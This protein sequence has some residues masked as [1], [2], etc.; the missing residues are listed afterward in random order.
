MI[1]QFDNAYI[2]ETKHTSYVMRV[3]PS[4][5]IEHLYYGPKITM[6]KVE[7]DPT[8]GESV[9]DPFLPLYEKH[10]FAPGDTAIYGPG[11]ENFTL[12]DMNL[13]YSTLG[14][15]DQREPLLI[16]RHGDGSVTS[17][18][19]VENVMMYSH[20]EH[21]GSLTTLPSSYGSCE[22][23]VFF[24]T[25]HVHSMEL[26]IHYLVYEAYDVICRFQK[27]INRNDE[28]VVLERFL[29]NQLDF[30]DSE[31]VFTTFNGAWTR[32]MNRND[33]LL[34]QGKIVNDSM[35][36]ASS[37]EANPFVMISRLGTTED[38]GQC[39]GCNLIYSGN[40]MEIA[41][42]S[43]YGKLHVLQGLHEKY[44]SWHL[45]SGESFE[46]PEAV[47]T[48]S[49]DGMNGMSQNMHEFVRNCIVRGRY[50]DRVRPVLLNSWEASYFH[51]TEESL[52]RLAKAGAKVGVELFVMDDGWFGKR[53]DDKH[54]LGDWE[55]N[56]EKLPG[57]LMAL[58]EKI[59]GLGMEFGIWV[60]PEMVNTDSDLY[61]RH[62]EWVLQIP[63][64]PHSEG[65]NQ[66]I[67]DLSQVEVQEYLIHAMSKVFSSAKI[68][69]VKWDMN[70]NWTDVY[71]NVY[72]T[73][74]QG[75]V[76]HRYMMGLYRVMKELTESFP[77]IL[78]EGC[79]S[80]GDRFDL[81]ILCYF[82]QIWAS[83]NTDALSRISIQTGLSYGY[84]L[85]T[86]GAH[87]S[88]VPNHQTLRITPLS[89]R[90]AVAAFG[91]LGYEMNLCDATKEELDAI[92]NQIATYKA[93]RSTIQWG[94][95]YRGRTLDGGLTGLAGSVQYGLMG[96]MTKGRFAEWTVVSKNR[97]RAMGMV[98]Q[99]QLI[100][101]SAHYT[102]HAK[103]LDGKKMYYFYH[104]PEVVNVQ[105]FG[106]LLNTM[107]PV[108]VKQDS[109][110]HKTIA[111]VVKLPGEKEEFMA[112]GDTLMYGGVKLSES[113]QGT[114]FN[115]KTRVMPDYGARLYYM[116]TEE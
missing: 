32:E 111:K 22:E 107:T 27:I 92:R 46:S 71:S 53:N 11:W 37:N 75:E 9:L 87:V 88:S 6:E 66:R 97:K 65:R 79:A 28:E 93:W 77:D 17:D 12:E 44:F 31:Y 101:S 63:S 109:I 21:P 45:A 14:K 84:P 116:Q 110:L 69:Y 73:D 74:H 112:Y 39:I 83:D 94:Q 33:H 29:S 78:F 7:A 2:L 96:E 58:S 8:L 43:A 5:Q 67:L 42:V 86:M 99:N 57:G 103:G 48:L 108:H 106:D 15:G 3:L 23:L 10:A 90:Y 70:R 61:R 41:Q 16:V 51:I 40:H 115:D 60:E 24:L 52:L 89:T 25:D 76:T 82:P 80:G 100:P 19:V 62:P 104:E 72:G 26:E 13:E 91:L 113:Y 50:R 56:R 102:Y 36:G 105:T 114:G 68:S 34:S 64:A 81:G 54:S 38:H 95:F 4:K 35:R 85:S 55:V 49:M 1:K 47:M 18:F 59:R 98:F 20:K 30:S